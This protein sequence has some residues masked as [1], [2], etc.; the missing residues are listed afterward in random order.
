MSATSI[1]P[2]KK[3]VVIVDRA[4]WGVRA[5]LTTK[6]PDTSQGQVVGT[7]CC[8][9]FACSQIGLTDRQI[10]DK[11]YPYS[12]SAAGL[13]AFAAAYPGLTKGVQ[14]KIGAVNDGEGPYIDYT[15]KE[16]EGELKALFL[17]AGVV[18]KFKG[19]K[20]K[21]KQDATR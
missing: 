15:A 16:K 9:G 14:R 4:T 21:G 19:R 13:K 7:R 11:N 2:A 3:P 8:L 17:D 10:A 18:L 5:L 1:K 6:D 12:L 20:P